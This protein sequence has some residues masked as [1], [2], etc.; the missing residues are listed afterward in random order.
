MSAGDAFQVAFNL[1]ADDFDF[2]GVVRRG[3]RL[4]GR[5]TAEKS[6]NGADFKIF[7]CKGS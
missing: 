4:I 1:A 5:K 6:K 3:G 2:S 7:I